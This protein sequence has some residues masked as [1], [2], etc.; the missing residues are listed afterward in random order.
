MEITEQD[1]FKLG[2]LTRCAE[3]KLTGADLDA[4]L[5][6]VAE[7]NKKAAWGDGLL[8][9]LG[10]SGIQGGL[11]DS[12]L[13]Y[14]AALSIPF[15]ASILGGSAL[16]YGAGKMVEPTINDDELKT[17]E[18]VDTYKLYA[19]KAKSRRKAVKYRT[20]RELAD[21][22]TQQSFDDIYGRV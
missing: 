18:L 17:R 20:K 6:K 15:G 21:S 19:D 8:S 16:G 11:K 1:A 5:E 2:F 22:S 7:L 3:E 10:L 14:G 13:A 9:S 12:L 4:R